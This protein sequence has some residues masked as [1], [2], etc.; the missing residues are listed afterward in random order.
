MCDFALAK[1]V[2]RAS[3]AAIPRPVTPACTTVAG[4]DYEQFAAGVQRICKEVD[5]SR[6]DFD[7]V[8]DNGKRLGREGR[9][10]GVQFREMMKDE[11]SPICFAD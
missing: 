6:E 1:Q 3:W 10:N 11:V 4:L 9:F 7:K 5:I 8:A 2:A